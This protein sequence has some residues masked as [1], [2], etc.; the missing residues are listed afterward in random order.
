MQRILQT[1]GEL[2]KRNVRLRDAVQAKVDECASAP[3]LSARGARSADVDAV[4]TL[5]KE[6]EELHDT[7]AMVSNE[8]IRLAQMA[9]DLVK[10]NATVLDAE[11]KTFRTEL[12]EQGIN[13]DEDVDD[14]YGY[15]QVQAQYH[16][17]MQKPQYQ[18]QRPAPMPQQQRAYGEH[19]MSSMDVGDLV[20]ANVGALNQ[21]SGGQEWIVATVTRYSPTEREFE[22]VDADEDAEKH[23]YRLPQKFV[24]PLPKTASVKQSQNFPA[25]TSVL[26]VYPNTTTFYKAKVV[27]PARRLP[28]A[29]YSEFVLEFEDDGDADG[30]AHRPVPFRH[31]VLFPR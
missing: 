21:S 30:Q 12:E 22:I 17:K 2:D 25:G 20:A 8:K 28:N 4:S 15:A 19:A 10:G 16:R 9:L 5:K 7:M 14:G 11:M 29:E 3:S 31:V 24:I 6:I 1:I 27:Q 13:P 18:Y 23:V 26:A